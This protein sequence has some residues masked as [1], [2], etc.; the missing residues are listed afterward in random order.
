MERLWKINRI[1]LEKLEDTFYIIPEEERLAARS[2]NHFSAAFR[3]KEQLE[4]VFY[5]QPNTI[6][7]LKTPRG[8][9][10]FF[11]ELQEGKKYIR[12]E[13]IRLLVAKMESTGVTA[14]FFVI[15]GPLS[16][17]ANDILNS[18]QA[19]PLRRV[20]VLRDE[21][22]MFNVTRHKRVPKHSLLTPSEAK[23]WL[24]QTKLKR[25]Q[26]PRLFENDP[27]AKYLGA[28]QGDLV[29]VTGS[30]PTV[31]TFVRILSV[32]RRLVR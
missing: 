19:P 2:L 26:L 21:E 29:R 24:E 11:A 27:Q 4:R 8:V 22:T 12:V 15:N 32:A 20:I 10:L 6:A 9:L 16:S 30:S 28:C 17:K 1:F 14:T 25:S 7:A 3:S 5:P 18:I 13:D 23:K 31:G